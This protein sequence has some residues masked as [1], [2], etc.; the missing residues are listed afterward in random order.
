MV[1]YSISEVPGALFSKPGGPCKT[2][3]LALT[4]LLE[5]PLCLEQLDTS[6]RVLPCQHTFC[7]TCLQRQEEAAHSQLLCPECGTPALVRTAEELPENLL[8]VRLLEGLQGL[9]G[10]DRDNQQ[11]IYDVPPGVEDQPLEG[12]NR[13][14]QAHSEVSA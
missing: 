2:E 7:L 13:E 5:C 3:T 11:V 12:Q 8:L 10:P 4:A 6:A 9:S 14:K 1:D